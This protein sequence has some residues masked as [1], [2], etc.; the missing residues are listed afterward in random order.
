MLLRR[1]EK[2]QHRFGKEHNVER[3]AP[4]F[5]FLKKTVSV[6]C[7]SA[8]RW[9]CLAF[10]C[11]FVLLPTKPNQT[12]AMRFI[13]EKRKERAPVDANPTKQKT[14]TAVPRKPVGTTHTKGTQCYLPFL[15]SN[16][17]SFCRLLRCRVAKWEWPYNAIPCKRFTH[18]TKNELRK[19]E[20]I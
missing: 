8:E 16:G 6:L 10:L 2:T 15:R 19:T 7:Q 13:A 20:L 1:P 9:R 17:I 3:T 11:L 5:V 18:R 14:A 4:Y 12:V